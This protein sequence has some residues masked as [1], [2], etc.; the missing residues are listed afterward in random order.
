MN[1]DQEN[2]EPVS[3]RGMSASVSGSL[4]RACTKMSKDQARNNVVKEILHA[5]KD[6]V[7]NLKDVIEV[8]YEF[9]K[10][11]VHCIDDLIPAPP[12]N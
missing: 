11:T 3:K 6:Y 8:R 10:D 4:R 2:I 9:L 1:E 7:K 12:N 5:E